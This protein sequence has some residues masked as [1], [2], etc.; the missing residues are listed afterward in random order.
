VRVFHITKG[1]VPHFEAPEVYRKALEQAG[2][3]VADESPL[4][5]RDW[6]SHYLFVAKKN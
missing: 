4:K 6:I 2:F 5:S 1:D 3:A